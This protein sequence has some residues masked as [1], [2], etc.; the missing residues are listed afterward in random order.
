MKSAGT[1]NCSTI[2]ELPVSVVNS[3]STACTHLMC[4]CVC[5]CAFVCV[6]VCACVCLCVDVRA[7]EC[8]FVRV[9]GRALEHAQTNT[10]T[11]TQT[12]KHTNAHAHTR[13]HTQTR[14]YAHAHTNTHTLSLTH[15]RTN[16]QGRAWRSTSACAFCSTAAK[17][18]S[19]SS[20]E[21]PAGVL[22]GTLRGTTEV[23]R[24]GATKVP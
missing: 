2:P 11:H 17:P 24:M 5:V 7:Q 9:S 18:D 22:P 8:V 1:A 13:A 14:S 12:R 19:S 10:V 16:P 20:C 23:N 3:S 21:Y 4:L 6:C 15:T